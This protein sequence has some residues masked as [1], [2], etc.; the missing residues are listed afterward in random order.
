[1]NEF[2][3]QGLIVLTDPSYDPQPWHNVFLYWAAILFAVA[4]NTIVSSWLPRFESVILVVHV[5]G[6]FAILL[7]LVILGPHAPA[8]E[9]FGK[10]I[11]DGDWPT[12]GLS[13]FVGLLGNVS[14]FFGADGAIHMAEEIQN[15]AVVV[16]RA[17]TFSILLNGTLCRVQH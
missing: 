4:I 11:N 17:I 5:L 9:V 14:A 3:L 8:S 10:F 16:P 7:P 13:F 2:I 1:M 6:F 12:D 15:A